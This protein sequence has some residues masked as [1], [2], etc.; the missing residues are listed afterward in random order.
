MGGSGSAAPVTRRVFVRSLT[1]GGLCVAATSAPALAHGGAPAVPAVATRTAY[2]FSTRGR[3]ACLAC[4][5]HAANRY[6]G[7]PQAAVDDRAHR[8]CN[9]AVIG[10]PLLVGTY[11]AY[12]NGRKVWDVRWGPAHGRRGGER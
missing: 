11:N 2:R 3:V 6:Y 7:T 10:Q 9:C 1:L 5:A 12:F 8:G 4:R